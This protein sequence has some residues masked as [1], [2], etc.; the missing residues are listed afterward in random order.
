MDH[1]ET[2]SI[3]I[4]KKEYKAPKEVMTGAELKALAQPPIGN[5]KDLFETVPK[6]DDIKIGDNQSV[7][8][9]NGMHFYSVPKTI[10]P[11]S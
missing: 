10:N 8:L 1:N 3:I 9:K 4:D 6:G 11:G 7:H 5:D 2:I